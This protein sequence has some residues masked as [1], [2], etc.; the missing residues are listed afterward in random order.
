VHDELVL[1][2][3][4]GKADEVADLVRSEMEGVHPLSVPLK[5]DACTGATWADLS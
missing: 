5:V 4:S 2:A 3:P 1:E